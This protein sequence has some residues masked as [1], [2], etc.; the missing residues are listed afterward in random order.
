MQYWATRI[1]RL[2]VSAVPAAAR[3]RFEDTR[4]CTE[5]VNY[6]SSIRL[7]LTVRISQGAISTVRR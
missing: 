6:F 4:R 3:L 1:L 5:R 2:A 7:T